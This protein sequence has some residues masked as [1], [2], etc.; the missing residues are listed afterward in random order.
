MNLNEKNPGHSQSLKER[1]W[2]RF[3]KERKTCVVDAAAFVVALKDVMGL[4]SGAITERV[5]ELQ[6][7]G[8]EFDAWCVA[9]IEA[10]LDRLECLVHPE[11]AKRIYN[12]NPLS[13]GNLVEIQMPS[14][15]IRGLVVMHDGKL[16]LVFGSMNDVGIHIYH[17]GEVWELANVPFPVE[18]LGRI[19]NGKLEISNEHLFHSP[20]VHLGKV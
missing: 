5:R 11:D 3:Q 16:G 18:V 13:P 20:A 15:K 8:W 4:D 9:E 19:E 17:E 7:E 14:A 2:D 1:V 6:R 10:L 12:V